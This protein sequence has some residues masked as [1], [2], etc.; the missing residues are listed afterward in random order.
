MVN[1]CPNLLPLSSHL[2]RVTDENMKGSYRF[3]ND[4]FITVFIF[5]FPSQRILL[6]RTNVGSSKYYTDMTDVVFIITVT[7]GIYLFF[8]YLILLSNNKDRYSDS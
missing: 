4:I 7:D 6:I 3:T 5:H 2:H 8:L 1:H